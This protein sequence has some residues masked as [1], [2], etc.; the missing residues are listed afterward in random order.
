M[1][2]A[3]SEGGQSEVEDWPPLLISIAESTGRPRNRPGIDRALLREHF[4]IDT[5]KLNSG[6]QSQ[7]VL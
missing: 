4:D 5:L 2:F 6:S 1:A 7:V 3:D